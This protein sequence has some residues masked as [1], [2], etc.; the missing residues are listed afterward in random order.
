MYSKF[1][2]NVNKKFHYF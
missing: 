2:T 1:V